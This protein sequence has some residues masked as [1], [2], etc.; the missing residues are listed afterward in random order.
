[1]LSSASD[2][3]LDTLENLNEVVDISTNVNL[4]KKSLGLNEGIEKVQQNLSAFLEKNKVEITNTIDD[5]VRVMSVPAYLES[6]ILNL[7]TNAVKYRHPK[8]IPEINLSASKEAKGILFSIT[9]NGLGID[10]DRYGDKMFGMYKTF[11]NN[12]DARGL[13]LYIIKNQI[14]A[15]DGYITVEST[16]NKG[17]VFKVFFNEENE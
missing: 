13:G 12:K 14:E 2:N 8:R 7:M 6:I 4:D 9:D 16:V 1:M 3:L 5:D 11:H 17:S 10:L 15:M